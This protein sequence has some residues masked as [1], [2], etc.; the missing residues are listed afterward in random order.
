MTSA[1]A[2][3]GRLAAPAVNDDSVAT[4]V[5]IDSSSGDQA[6]A[7]EG[8]G[9][10]F[11]NARLVTSATFVQGTTVSGGDGWFEAN[12]TLQITTNGSSWTDAG[13]SSTPAYAYSSAV[14]GKT[15]VF[16]GSAP[17][18]GVRGVRVVGQVNTVGDSWWAAV[19]ELIVLGF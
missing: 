10:V 15:Y 6:N 14:S 13:W 16:T 3:T 12:F 19:K 7:W 9:V 17:L 2:D 4:Q 8:A 18:T 11:T 5:N 1:S